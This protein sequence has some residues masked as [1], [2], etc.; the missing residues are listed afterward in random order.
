MT[1]EE[2]NSSRSTA[3]PKDDN[4]LI[5]DDDTSPDRDSVLSVEPIQEEDLKATGPDPYDKLK[6]GEKL[7]FIHFLSFFHFVYQK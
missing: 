3:A 2:I 6:I 1:Y 5:K 4:K 7:N